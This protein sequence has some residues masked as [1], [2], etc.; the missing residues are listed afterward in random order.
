M[1]II[2]TIRVIFMN[3]LAKAMQVAFLD[4]VKKRCQNN[5][6]HFKTMTQAGSFSLQLELYA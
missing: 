1:N 2:M 5:K 4:L 6:Q 3:Y